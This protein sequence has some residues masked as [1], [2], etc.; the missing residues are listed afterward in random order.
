[1]SKDMRKLLAVLALT[2]LTGCCQAFVPKWQMRQTQLRSY[3]FY[4][5]AQ[6]LSGQ[7]AQSESMVQHLAMEKQQAETRA[8]QLDQ[9]LRIA[10]ERLRNLAQERSK[11][12]EQYK[13][14]LTSLPAPGASNSGM[15]KLFEGLCRRHPE[16]EFDPVSGSARYNV[17]IQFASGSN[18]LHPDSLRVLQNLTKIMNDPENRHFNLLVVGHTD[19][20]AVVRPET[21]ARHETN[22]ELSA[23]RATGVVRQLAKYG[24]AE[25]RMGIAGYNK[26]Q[27]AAPNVDASSKQKNRRVEIYVVASDTAIASKEGGT[28]Q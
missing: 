13:T 16:F 21:R 8:A 12:N 11:L 18:E 6:A 28:K 5:Q 4:E 2:S 26:Y 7:L 17:E 14:L 3:Q 9:E 24:V 1:M 15:S 23:H 10:N 19:D 20:D 25:S 27:P 22:W